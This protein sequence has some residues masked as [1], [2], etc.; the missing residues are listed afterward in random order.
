MGS[1]EEAVARSA[2]DCYATGDRA[3]LV[4][5]YS[6][7]AVYHVNAWQEPLVGRDAIRAEIDRQFDLVSDYRTTIVNIFSKDSVVFS[8]GIDTFKHSRSGGKD[9]TSHWARVQEINPA[10]KIISLRDYWDSQEQEGQLA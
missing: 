1:K 2:I 7:E 8:E 6:D 10:G 5:L 4:D 9:V 3:A